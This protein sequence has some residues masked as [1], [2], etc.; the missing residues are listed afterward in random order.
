MTR[1][2]DVSGICKYRLILRYVSRG[3]S[4]FRKR[5]REYLLFNVRI[6]NFRRN[7]RIFLEFINLTFRRFRNSKTNLPPAIIYP[8]RVSI[9]RQFHLTSSRVKKDK[10]FFEEQIQRL[11]RK[12]KK[13]K[14]NEIPKLIDP[15]NTTFV[16]Y[17]AKVNLCNVDSNSL[18]LIVPVF[19]SIV[20]YRRLSR[21]LPS[22]RDVDGKN[23]EGTWMTRGNSVAVAFRG[24][25]R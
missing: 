7:L 16:I 17:L 2:T 9:S 1:A 10:F 19:P 6:L 18:P 13:K 14:S 8:A 20:A 5:K 21:F 25:K 12:R 11:L 23:V 15:Y 22:G 4:F 24:N 3:I